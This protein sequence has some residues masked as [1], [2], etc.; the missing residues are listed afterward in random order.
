MK[1]FRMLL[2]IAGLTL[3]SCNFPLWGQGSNQNAGNAAGTAAALTVAAQLTEN[4]WQAPGPVDP[5]NPSAPPATRAPTAA[6]L[7][8]GTPLP[9]KTPAEVLPCDRVSFVKDVTV[10]D[11]TEFSG[12]ESFTKTWRLKNTGSCTWDSDY[13][14]VF[15]TGESMEG[16]EAVQL[17]SGTVAP[18]DTVDASV[19]LNAPDEAGTYKGNYKLRNADGEEFGLGNSGVPF[20]VEIEVLAPVSFTIEFTGLYTCPGP[21]YHAAAKIT[22]TGTETLESADISLYDVTKNNKL[23]VNNGFLDPFYEDPDSCSGPPIAN[24][25]P[26]DTYYVIIMSQLPFPS[27]HKMRLSVTLCDRDSA[28]GRVCAERRVTFTVP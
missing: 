21:S 15:T 28:S 1:K 17:T 24:A 4:A 18:G 12:G 16:P 20:Y 26:G 19:K 10:P 9:S 8:S 22:N 23:W 25:E 14:L 2:M 5:T 27:D 6:P 11:G 3:L 13:D 7:P